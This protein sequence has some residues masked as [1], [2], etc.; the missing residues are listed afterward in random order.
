MLQG[1]FNYL[2][3]IDNDENCYKIKRI[4]NK[5]NQLSLVQILDSKDKIYKCLFIKYK[6]KQ[7]KGEMYYEEKKNDGY[8]Y[9]SS[10]DGIGI[11]RMWILQQ[12]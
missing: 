3:L 6:R 8:V 2:D 7:T 11:D 12:C 1:N 9:G 4:F 5:E 10:Y